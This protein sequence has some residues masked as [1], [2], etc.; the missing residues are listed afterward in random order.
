MVPLLLFVVVFTFIPAIWNF[1]ISLQDYKILGESEFVG[2]QNYSRVLGDPLFWNAFKNTV[3]LALVIV[4][5]QVLFG[6]FF[7]SLLN[8]RVRGVNVF[9][10][11][12][13]IPVIVSWVIVSVVFKWIFAGGP[14]G[15][16]NYSLLS[17][18]VIGQPVNWFGTVA[19]AMPTVMLLHIWKGI[20]W[21]TIILLAAMQ[22][23]PQ[24]LYD[25][26]KV[27]VASGWKKFRHITLPFIS[28]VLAI[29]TVLVT[30]G[31]FTSFTAMYVI[32][33]GGPLHSTEVI[34]TYMYKNAITFLDFG[35]A[36]AMV[37]FV[38]PIILGISFLQI[39]I[40]AKP[41]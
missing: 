31:A 40:L 3:F 24:S 25:A 41:Q 32:T 30:G 18:G 37:F 23:V 38:L 19:T 29:V 20:G 39:K 27:D 28:P 13:F 33:Q 2:L 16:A 15:L 5:G 34:T 22:A 26:A 6:L 35:F 9:R 21:S 12:Y 10:F 8:E 4:P 11:L 7:A 14:S 36:A 1:N 17:M